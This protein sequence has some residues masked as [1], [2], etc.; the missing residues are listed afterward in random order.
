MG[1][2][3]VLAEKPSVGRDIAKV[4]NCHRKGAGFLEGDKYIITW[5]LG[6]LVT[7]ATPERYGEQYKNWSIEN[8][9]MLP[10]HLKTEVISKTSKHFRDVKKVLNRADVDSLII[11]T[12][13]AREGELVA[14]WIVEKC[15]FKKP[16]QRLWISSQTD[17]AI[18]DGFNNLKP[19]ST[20]D[21]L[22]KA[23]VCRAEADWIL[24]LN[25]TRALTCKF[26]AQL[27][28]GRVQ[29][30]TLAMIVNR[31]HEINTFKPKNYYTITASSKKVILRWQDD[32]GNSRLWDEAEAKAMVKKLT[33]SAAKVDAVKD[34]LKKVYSPIFYDLTELQRDANRIF[35]YSAKETL[36]IMQRLYEQ[37]KIL[38]YPRTDSKHITTDI[39][40][41]L[42]DRFQAVAV[43]EYRAV[44][45]G[46]SKQNIKVDKRFADNNKVSDH[47]GIIPT[48]E[49]VNLLSLSADEKK[50]YDLVLKR[51]L[52]VF[53][54]PYE[55]LQTTVTCKIADETFIARGRVVKSEGYRA[56]YKDGVDDDED[57]VD[58]KKELPPIKQGETLAID[59]VAY[60]ADKT[61][62]PT[63]FNEGTLL[64]AM[65]KPHQVMNISSNL[66]KTLGETGGIGTVATRAEI[67]DKLFNSYYIE[68]NDKTI[69][70]TSKGKQL[71]ELVPT[72]LKSPVMTAKWEQDFDLI[73]K[74]KKSDKEFINDM[75]AY[76]TKLVN[77]VK[78]S[79]ARF[80]HD[81]KTGK[82]CP[83]CNKNL[84]E[85]KT[86]I[87]VRHVC[88][89]R[90][91]GYKV[92]ISK[93]TNT[94]CP[95]CH[96]KLELKGHKDAQSYVCPGCGF[97][98]R[99]ESFNKKYRSGGSKAD[100]KA[101]QSYLKNQDKQDEGNFAF[102]AAFANLNDNSNDKSR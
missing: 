32:K 2:I 7:L 22:Y 95:T 88:Q 84:L 40:P 54:P 19:A 68:K 91:C 72:E 98:E 21:N 39:V 62:P 67:I 63:R 48:E 65:E 80:N 36:S 85:V 43:G 29:S 16:M 6:H 41:T 96:K 4:F 31:E 34:T 79:D 77:E 46:L 47:H 76:T 64:A 26:N 8:L 11:A 49:R 5:G 100:K 60:K 58:D 9:P 10:K 15:G 70:P 59:N 82:K 33:G 45:T 94:K 61:K 69:T 57:E 97:K 14:R 35:G 3:V 51:F 38:T 52:A 75:K 24:G 13:P 83:Q 78:N 55:Y 1:K 87:G 66:A 53:M 17:K 90:E 27:S 74:G 50:I 12:D 25:V 23:A 73:S 30:A 86:K 92:D 89:D 99:A 20:Y 101:V 44:A 93:F 102:A 81:N 18:R 56:L 42:K 37:H 71:I 28:A